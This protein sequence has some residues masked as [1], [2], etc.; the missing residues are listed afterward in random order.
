MR[1]LQFIKH[2]LLLLKNRASDSSSCPGEA[3]I[4]PPILPT[5]QPNHNYTSRHHIQNALL[6]L[7]HCSRSLCISILH[8]FYQHDLSHTTIVPNLH[9]HHSTSLTPIANISLNPNSPFADFASIANLRL[10]TI[11]TEPRVPNS[12]HIDVGVLPHW[13][14]RLEALEHR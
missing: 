11:R 6:H 3:S 1:I 8:P 4:N 10:N 2:T 5:S 9:T 14:W 12:H 7:H 13:N